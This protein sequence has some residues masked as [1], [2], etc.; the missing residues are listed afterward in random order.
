VFINRTLVYGT[1]TVLLSAVF[2]GLII[3]LS[4]LLRGIISH[5]SGVAIVLSTVAIYFL[6][7]PL[8]RRIQQVID[9]RFYRRKY[10]AA[11]VVAAFSATLRQEVD[12][13]Q[14]REQL[15]AV[16]QE[17]M[18]PTS[19][20]LW[21]CHSHQEKR[22]GV[23]VSLGTPSNPSHEGRQSRDALGEGT[24]DRVR[25]TLKAGISM[26]KWTRIL[27]LIVAWLF[28]VAML[29]Q[30]FL[31]GLSLFTGQAYWSTHRDFGHTLGVFPLLL[32]MLAYLG[33]LPRSEKRLIWLQFGV[34]LVQA[35]VFAA[36][37]DVAPFLA[38]FHPVLALVLFALSF[39]LAL[40]S[41]T[42]V[43]AEGKAHSTSRHSPVMEEKGSLAPD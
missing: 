37:R 7:Q 36:I 43:R 28:P 21:L 2:V 23:P 32:V 33:R 15:V 22:A 26:V 17:T 41:P 27:Y 10:D 3:G 14:L 16:V 39:I 29:I 13:E 25:W 9:R 4:A 24:H 5:D 18:Q 19:V 38:A 11:K 6:F 35:E 34:Y 40:R 20:S 12:L 8:R 30:V 1:L 31:V 42:L